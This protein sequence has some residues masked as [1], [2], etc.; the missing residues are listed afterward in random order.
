M[1]KRLDAAASSKVL[2]DKTEFIRNKQMNLDM[3]SGRLEN[4]YRN[5]LMKNKNDFTGLSS[6]LDALSPLKVLSRGYTAVTK[7]EKIITSAD[8]IYMGDK[9][10]VRF[11]DGI[12]KCTVNERKV[13]R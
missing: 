12:A 10:D 4:S 5:I 9:I 1:Q 6:R 13:T 11:S 3:L 7:E 8:E 2:S